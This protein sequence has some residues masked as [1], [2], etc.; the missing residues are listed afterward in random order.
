MPETWHTLHTALTFDQIDICDITAH[1]MSL[2]AYYPSHVILSTQRRIQTCR[3]LK[4]KVFI[5]KRGVTKQIGL[6]QKVPG[7]TMTGKSLDKHG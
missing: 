6:M 5:V 3:V 1:I 7:L 4:I 2:R